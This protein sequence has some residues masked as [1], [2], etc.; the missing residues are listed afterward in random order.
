MIQLEVDHTHIENLCI[1]TVTAATIHD[2]K[3]FDIIDGEGHLSTFQQDTELQIHLHYD[4]TD[5]FLAPIHF[6]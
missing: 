1:P 5:S 4:R 2:M 6:H 3:E